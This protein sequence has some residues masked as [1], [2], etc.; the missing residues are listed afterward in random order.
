MSSNVVHDVSEI[1]VVGRTVAVGN[2]GSG[3]A[4]A[5]PLRDAVDDLVGGDVFEVDVTAAAVPVGGEAAS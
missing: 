1:L 5:R 2:L 4:D 3:P